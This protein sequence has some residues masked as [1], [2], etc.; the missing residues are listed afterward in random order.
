[1]EILNATGRRKTSVARVYLSEGKGNF[2][3][4]GKK[5][6]EYFD[7]FNFNFK[8]KLKEQR[9]GNKKEIPFSFD[10]FDE[11]DNID[12]NEKKRDFSEGLSEGERQVLSLCFFFAFTIYTFRKAFI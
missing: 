6:E 8:L 4:N 11:N 12:E 7:Y 1:M 5:I 3:I 9:I 10:I 2:I